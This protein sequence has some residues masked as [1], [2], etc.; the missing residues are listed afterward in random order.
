[1]D[2]QDQRLG[3]CSICS[4]ACKAQIQMA[5]D[6]MNYRVVV[7]F[8]VVSGVSIGVVIMKQGSRIG[9]FQ[10]NDNIYVDF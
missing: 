4:K 3:L 1:M 10:Q 9:L 8:I 5:N 7:G 6:D 2:R